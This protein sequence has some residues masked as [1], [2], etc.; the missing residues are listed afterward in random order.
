MTARPTPEIVLVD[1]IGDSDDRGNPVGHVTKTLP[2]YCELLQGHF[3]IHL[4][5]PQHYGNLAR[6]CPGVETMHTFHNQPVPGMREVRRKT[7]NLREVFSLYRGKLVWF[8]NTDF[9]L[10]LFRLRQHSSAVRTVATMYAQQFQPFRHALWNRLINP[11]CRRGLRHLDLVISN[12]PKLSFPGRTHFIPDFPYRSGLYDSHIQRPKMDQAVCCGIMREDKDLEGLVLAFNE[13][14][15]PLRVVGRFKDPTRREQLSRTTRSSITVEDRL[16]TDDEF[17][18]L[19]GE[20]RF[21]VFPYKAEKYRH[22]TSG[23]LLESVY[24]DCLPVAPRQL[25]EFLGFQGIGYDQISELGAIFHSRRFIDADNRS[26]KLKYG[27]EDVRRGLLAALS[28]IAQ[29]S[30]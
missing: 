1:Y 19:L 10:P 16:L 22:R 27:F 2:D 4:A 11:L 21:A 18:R 15:Y 8:V 17:Y 7:A 29:E 25:L 20:S 5:V 28:G 30:P 26:V 13:A 23:I 24:L 9:L 12:H 14:D 6:G 3:R